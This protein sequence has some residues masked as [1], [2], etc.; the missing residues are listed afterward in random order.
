MVCMVRACEVHSLHGFDSGSDQFELSCIANGFTNLTIKSPKKIAEQI[1]WL[2]AW[3]ALSFDVFGTA[4]GFCRYLRGSRSLL[5][6]EI[7]EMYA[8]IRH[9]RTYADV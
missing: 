5:K 9:L 6:M 1:L 3:F 2:F 8:M 4:C 7:D